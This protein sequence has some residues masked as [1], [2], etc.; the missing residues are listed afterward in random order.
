MGNQL[1]VDSDGHILEPPDLWQRYLEPKYR[2][3]AI[4]IRQDED[5]LEYLEVD[6]AK[7]AMVRVGN[8]GSLGGA[9]QDPRELLTP[10]RVTYWEVARRTPGAIDPDARIKE[11]DEQRIDFALLYPT[12]GILWEGE[13]ADAE[14]SAAY[15]RAYNNYL[16]DFCS[17]HPDRLVPIAHINLRDVRLAAK[18]VERV[19]DKA[20]GV[21]ITPYPA[22]G[23]P[24]G[25]SYYDPFWVACEAANLPV[26]THVQVRPG[27]LGMGLYRPTGPRSQDSTPWFFFMELPE[28]SILGLNCVFQDGV[29]SR[30][31]RLRYVILE[32]GCGWLPGW[33]NRADAKYE[34]FAFT[35]QMTAKPSEI[36]RERCWI[37][38]DVDETTIPYVAGLL[39]ARR[40]LWGSD[41]PH[42]DAHQNPVGE[43]R[44]HIS[45]LSSEEQEWILGRAA[46]ELYGL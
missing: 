15:C 8:L 26:S 6:G 14:L 27:A 19:K 31:P 17:P 2:G 41:Y 21:F 16:F 22:N 30:F 44:K 11:M 38:A 43:L 35:T 3:R 28:D 13:C 42:I 45:G 46:L 10:G 25:D 23:R 37:S 1:I 20:K 18:E 5:R 12:I 29:L 32:T 4:R 9:Y 36:F 33:M 34:R 40:M 24:I 39:G 7:S